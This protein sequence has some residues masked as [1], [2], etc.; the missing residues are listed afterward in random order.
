MKPGVVILGG[1]IAGLSLASFLD[2]RAIVLECQK[3][4]GGLSRSYAM[5][6]LILPGL[7][8]WLCAGR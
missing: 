3:E 2:R 4:V 7:D 8:W 6:S 1:G 5:L